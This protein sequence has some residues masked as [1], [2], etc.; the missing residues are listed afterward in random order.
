[1]R[2]IIFMAQYKFTYEAND[3]VEAQ[4]KANALS[5][6][7]SKLPLADLQFIARKINANPQG[8]IEKLHKFQAFI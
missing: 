7:A 1:M 2:R 3:G 4:A 5:V 6:I 8:I